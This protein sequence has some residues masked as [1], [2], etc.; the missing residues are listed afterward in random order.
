MKKRRLTSAEVQ[1]M[2][3]IY[4]FRKGADIAAMYGVSVSKIYT[5]AKRYSVKKSAEFLNSPESG[6]ISKGQHFSPAT[7]I[8]MGQKIYGSRNR[9]VK[10]PHPTAWRKGNIGPLTAENG[11]IRWRTVG[12]MIRIDVDK[13][14][15]YARWLWKQQHG[16]IPEG[17][18]VVYKQGE[19]SKK[20]IPTIDQLQCVSNAELLSLNSGSDELTDKYIVEK[21]SHL[22]PALRK[23][24]SEMSELIELKRN[25]L[26][27]RRKI[28]ELEKIGTND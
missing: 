24:F 19:S 21:L 3:K 27:L 8:K 16:D 4:P 15:F 9:K 2:L 13:W 12:W 5:T 14:E 1:E 28:N 11:E 25:E 17:Y 10:K 20:H 22:K 6:R 23:A 26:K 7:Q 18:N